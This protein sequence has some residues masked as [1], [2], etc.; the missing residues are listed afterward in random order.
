[1]NLHSH[2]Q[3]VAPMLDNW[4]LA[5]NARRTGAFFLQPSTFPG[6]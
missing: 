6:T 5:Y 3:L 4:A 2:K 1:M